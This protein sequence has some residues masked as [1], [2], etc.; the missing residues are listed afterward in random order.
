MK[1]R[2]V[3]ALLC[4]AGVAW[5][6]RAEDVLPAKILAQLKAA[7]VYV[8]VE[9]GRY[10]ACGSGFAFHAHGRTVYLATNEHVVM[11]PG[12]EIRRP[13]FPP[14]RLPPRV[15]KVT[16]VFGSGTRHERELPA[17]VIF[18]DA[19][20]DLAL[21]KVDRDRDLP[22]PIV[23]PKGLKLAETMPVYVLGYPFGDDLDPHGKNPAVTVGKGAVSSL[24]ED[25]KGGLE[26]IQIEAEVHP[27]N[28]GGPVVDASG[29]LVGVTVAKVRGTRIGMVIPAAHLLQ[30]MGGRFVEIGLY[31]KRLG[32]RQSVV[33]LNLLLFDPLGQ[34]QSARVHWLPPDAAAANPQPGKATWLGDLCL[35]TPEEGQATLPFQIVLSRKGGAPQLTRVFTY[36]WVPNPKAPARRP[37]AAGE[38]ARLAADLKVPSENYRPRRAAMERLVAAEPAEPRK[39]VLELIRPALD[40]ADHFLRESS[41]RALG[42]WAGADGRADLLRRLKEEDF[43]WV[44]WTLLEELGKLAGDEACRA[45]VAS[46]ARDRSSGVP[47]RVLRAF[48]PAAEKH[49]LPLLKEP[50]AALRR[51]ACRILE[52]VGT[53][54]SITA[55]ENTAKKDGDPSVTEAARMALEAIKDRR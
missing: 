9:A 48:G 3:L 29:Q 23:I 54:E 31:P 34:I 8:K 7:T 12:L 20:R 46:L 45:V 28:S 44:R 18:R 11:V 22:D 38:L 1:T 10:A 24:R 32:P 40:D 15:G 25:P 6:V 33:C 30:L 16:V 2:F 4:V 52:T 42:V 41:A 50:D 53:K 37:L 13:R 17:T 19:E 55:L 14:I 35:P 51:E 36:R 27:G 21:L 5:P 43:P 26:V 39:E 47:T 49:V